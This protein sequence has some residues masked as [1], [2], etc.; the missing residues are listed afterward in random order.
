[1]K[2]II[3]GDQVFYLENDQLPGQ[4]LSNPYYTIFTPLGFSLEKEYIYEPI[5]N[6]NQEPLPS[7]PS[8]GLPIYP[9]LQL[10]Y[11][12]VIKNPWTYWD[13]T[14]K[15]ESVRL[16]RDYLLQQTDWRAIRAYET[17]NPESQA[18]LDYRQELRDFPNVVNVNLPIEQIVWPTPPNS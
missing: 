7:S 12:T 3:Q 9:P 17:G 11:K 8:R 10:K 13:N 16:Q 4:P 2:I 1:M 6:N 5:S 18:W 14:T 15:I